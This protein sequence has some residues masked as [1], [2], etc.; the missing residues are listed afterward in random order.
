[1]KRH[2]DKK[3]AAQ[4]P[5]TPVDISMIEEGGALL[6]RTPEGQS[7]YRSDADTDGKSHC[8]GECSKEWP[9]VVPSEGAKPI[10]DW[11]IITR[12]DGIKQWCY[13]QHPVYTYALDFPGRSGGDGKGGVWHV[14]KL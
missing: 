3:Q 10:G 14:V 7:M 4:L 2:Y 13:Q 11:T 12:S 1:M 6:L 9:P 5:P 8:V